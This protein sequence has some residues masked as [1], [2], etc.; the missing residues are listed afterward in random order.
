[1][2][3]N[4]LFSTMYI[5]GSARRPDERKAKTMSKDLQNYNSAHRR[6][7]AECLC[8]RRLAMCAGRIF[9]WAHFHRIAELRNDLQSHHF[10][11]WTTDFRNRSF[12]VRRI[13]TVEQKII[14]VSDI[15]EFDLNLPEL[16]LT[17]ALSFSD[18]ST[19]IWCSSVHVYRCP[20][21]W[22]VVDKYLFLIQR[23]A[24]K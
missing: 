20:T 6:W 21:K 9:A 7:E 19:Y 8:W 1:M 24:Q 2:Q 14:F 16:N 12:E 17:S 3:N 10:Q 13:S 11:W 18:I 15:F 4:W 5:Y 23:Q 22:L